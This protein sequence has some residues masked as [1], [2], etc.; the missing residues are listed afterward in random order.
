[1]LGHEHKKSVT[2]AQVLPSNEHQ[3]SETRCLPIYM[4]VIRLDD[5]EKHSSRTTFQKL[6]APHRQR[7][8]H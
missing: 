4:L 7:L 8:H 1:M 5:F 6:V 3:M 2:E